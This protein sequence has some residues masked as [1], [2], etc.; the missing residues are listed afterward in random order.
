M[1]EGEVN[2]DMAGIAMSIRTFGLMIPSYR[3][4]LDST[5]PFPDETGFHL[6]WSV[7][8]SETFGWRVDTENYCE[9][10]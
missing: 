2:T 8:K 7:V 4:I 5:L 9:I 6:C 10:V 3:Y 1:Y